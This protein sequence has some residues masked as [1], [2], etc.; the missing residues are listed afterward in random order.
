MIVAFCIVKLL[1]KILKIVL[2]IVGGLIF[3]LYLLLSNG[4]VLQRDDNQESQSD[5]LPNDYQYSNNSPK[6]YSPLSSSDVEQVK[7]FIFFLGHARSGHSIVGSILDAHPHVIL[8]HEAK[9]FVVLSADLSSKKPQYNNKSMILNALWNNSFHSSTLGLRTEEEK[10]LK[11]GYSLSIDGLYQGTFV[12]P[13]QVIGDK[14]G[15]KTTA[16]FMTKPLKWEQVFFK[17]KSALNIPIKVIH[18]I[19]NP[20][21]NI[22]TSILYKSKGI[23]VSSVK[24]SNKSYEVDVSVMEHY[25]NKYFDFYRAI[26]MVK[27]KYNLNLLEVHGKDLIEN[28]KATI[29]S[30]CSFLGLSCSDNYLE[31]CSSKLFKTESKTRHKLAWTKQLISVVQDSIMNFKSLKRYYS[32]DS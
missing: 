32:F 8:A 31:T 2:P 14:S 22:A 1:M 17:L 10:A 26:Q 20:Y 23:K 13:I 30:M 25:I 29:L 11:K 12:P 18:V 6:Q 15:G 24:Q 21:D 28:P 9:L 16:L 3:L 7:T 27:Y 4:Y 19:R 5:D